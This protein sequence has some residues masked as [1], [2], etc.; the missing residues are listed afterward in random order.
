MGAKMFIREIQAAADDEIVERF[1]GGFVKRFMDNCHC[2]VGPYT[3]LIAKKVQTP[4]NDKFFVL[5]SDQF[6]APETDALRYPMRFRWPFDFSQYVGADPSR[7]KL[8]ILESVHAA[9]LW[10]LTGNHWETQPFVEARQKLLDANLEWIDVSKSQWVHPKKKIKV[11]I[12]VRLDLDKFSLFLIVYKNRTEHEVCRVPVREIHP[13]GNWDDIYLKRA[14]WDPPNRFTIET[15]GF[16]PDPRYLISV[17]I[18]E[19]LL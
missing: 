3:R 2:I 15:S 8:A 10:M 19:S 13:C 12:G 11:R 7:K 6:S 4:L 9:C 16:S 1:K 5:F 18:P 17:D 14:K